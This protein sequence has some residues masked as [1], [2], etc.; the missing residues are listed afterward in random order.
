VVL[1]LFTFLPVFVLNRFIADIFFYSSK[2]PE[3]ALFSFR[4]LKRSVLSKRQGFGK[5]Y[6]PQGGDFFSNPQDRDLAC[7]L[8]AREYLCSGNENKKQYPVTLE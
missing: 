8:R 7:A 3:Y 2:E 5:K 4:E 6:D 1:F